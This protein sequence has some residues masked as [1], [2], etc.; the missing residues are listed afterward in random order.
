MAIKCDVLIIGGGPAGSTLAS[1]LRK[2]NP[3]LSI[4]IVERENFP[5]DHIGES[6]LTAVC[7]VLN[8]MGAWEKV[9]AA[10]FPVKIGSTY[11]WGKTD[12][13]W[14]VNF[15]V[16][17]EY[18]DLPRPAKFAGQRSRTAFQVDRSIYDEILLDHAASMG[19]EVREG[20]KALSVQKDGDRVVSV[21]ITPTQG[22]AGHAEEVEARYYIDAS[23]GSGFLRREVGVEIDSPT[24][25]RNVA[26][27]KYWRNTEWAETVGNGGTRAQIMSIGWGWIWFIPIGKTRTSVGVVTP[28]AYLKASGK[29]PEQLYAEGL[30]ADPRISKLIVNAQVEDKFYATKDWSYL[31]SNLA[32]E[33]W[34]LCGDACGF[35]DPILSAGMT[36]AQVGARKLAYTILELE[37]KKH[38]PEWLKAEF[39]RSHRANISQHIRFAEFWYSANGQFSD[40]NDYCAEIASDA[41][42][43]LTPEDAFQWIGT[44]GFAAD[45]FSDINGLTQRFESSRNLIGRMLANPDWEAAKHNVF[46][47][48]TEGATPDLVAFYKDGGVVPVRCFRRGEKVLPL[49]DQNQFVCSV[50]EHESDAVTVAQIIQKQ[51]LANPRNFPNPRESYKVAMEAI[52]TL[53]A[54]GWI[55]ASVNPDRPFIPLQQPA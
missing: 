38:A 6:Q 43:K 53:I 14:Q 5:R 13:L 31:A 16:N 25:L 44:G 22:G 45:T 48:N 1:L 15:L 7:L 32:G 18:G 4:L 50:I 20:W 11:R 34:F 27:Y 49:I 30:A 33:N 46:R 19:C 37:R 28:A 51:L 35:A 10:G 26:L 39:T 29:A 54:Q 47:L 23:G 41:G 21:T 17:E 42:L 2:Y 24:C 55:T 9:E 3:G 36:L 52:E 40:L 8:E 12:D